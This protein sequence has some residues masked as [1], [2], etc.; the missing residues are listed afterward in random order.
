MAQ[1]YSAC[2]LPAGA[3]GQGG[4]GTELTKLDTRTVLH[5]SGEKSAEQ[6]EPADT[7]EQPTSTATPGLPLFPQV[8]CLTSP[9]AMETKSTTQEGTGGW[10][11]RDDA[12]TTRTCAPGTRTHA[13]GTRTRAGWGG[14]QGMSPS[15]VAGAKGAVLAEGLRLMS[16]GQAMWGGGGL[17]QAS[18]VI[19]LTAT[20]SVPS[21][22]V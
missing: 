13:P 10:V 16:W 21:Y 8:L 22:T 15:P 19:T 9:V 3:P 18:G 4:S 7:P 12:A 5:T 2:P 11:D 14:L 17:P 6:T 20:A 1:A